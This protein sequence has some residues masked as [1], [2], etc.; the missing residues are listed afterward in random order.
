MKSLNEALQAL[1]LDARDRARDQLATEQL[2]M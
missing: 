1:L 2:P